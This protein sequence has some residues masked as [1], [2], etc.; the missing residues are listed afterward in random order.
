MCT[1]S[2]LNRSDRLEIFCN[3][4]EQRTRQP[5]LPPKKD[6]RNGTCYI[7]PE[8]GDA[9]GSWIAANE[10]GLAVTLLN[11][12]PEITP[13][14]PSPIESRGLLV[15]ELMACRDTADV[16]ATLLDQDLTRFRPFWLLSMEPGLNIAKY[17]WDGNSL[18]RSAFEDQVWSVT[19]SSVQNRAASAYRS[20]RFEPLLEQLDLPSA[21]QLRAYHLSQEEEHKDISVRMEREFSLTVS[22]SHIVIDPDGISFEYWDRTPFDG[23]HTDKIFLKRSDL[24]RL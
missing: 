16:H 6:T 12:Y 24:S 5:A 18:Y 21:K 8:D 4:D 10:H 1:V 20:V 7:S 3:R 23:E 15:L 11:H 13:S 22:V 9:K 2:W 17:Q 14:A 19:T